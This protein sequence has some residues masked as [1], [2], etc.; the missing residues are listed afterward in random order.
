M[1]LGRLLCAISC[2]QT[3]VF[4]A[5][6]TLHSREYLAVRFPDSVG[7]VVLAE[8]QPWQMPATHR[9]DM[10]IPSAWRIHRSDYDLEIRL[11]PKDCFPQLLVTARSRGDETLFVQPSGVVSIGLDYIRS[12]EG[13]ILVQ[14]FAAPQSERS[15]DFIVVNSKG[16]RVAHETLTANL[17]PCGT[18]YMGESWF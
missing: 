7:A 10:A 6:C 15:L 9:L 18:C 3:I 5:G 13:E 11:A 2:A 14:V 17:E 16:V 1:N 12:G 4:S 8:I